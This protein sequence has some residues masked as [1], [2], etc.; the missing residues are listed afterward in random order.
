ME[1]IF[2]NNP[3]QIQGQERN[4]T[5]S[6]LTN[7]MHPAIPEGNIYILDM[8]CSG[9]FSNIYGHCLSNGAFIIKSGIFN[10]ADNVG[11]IATINGYFA[12]FQFYADL[13]SGKAGFYGVGDGINAALACHAFDEVG[14][15]GE[16][17]RKIVK[18]R[19]GV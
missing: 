4:G 10:C 14:G 6:I 5:N 19:G 1:K 7:V 13:R 18:R 12:A 17:L 16:Y 2:R 3:V 15:H 9:D 11:G 8:D